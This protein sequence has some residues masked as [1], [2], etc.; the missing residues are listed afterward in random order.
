MGIVTGGGYFLYGDSVMLIASPNPS[1]MFDHWHDGDTN[2]PRYVMAT[3]DA[4]YIAYFSQNST[5]EDASINNMVIYVENG[6]IIVNEQ[7]EP[8]RVFDITGR[9]VKNESLPTGTYLIKIGNYPVCKVV[10]IR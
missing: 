5:I 7:T 8:V 9:E 10:V 3:S 2:N 6:R 1:F 4:T